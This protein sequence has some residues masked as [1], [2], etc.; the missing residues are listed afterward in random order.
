MIKVLL[1]DDEVL[2]LKGMQTF[3]PWGELGMEV[4]AAVTSGFAASEIIERESIDILVTDVRMPNMSGLE[5]ARKA[6]DIQENV[7][8]I[9]VSGYQDFHYVKQ[10]L[11]LNACSYI[12]KPMDDNELIE[13]LRKLRI[14]LDEEKKLIETELIYKRMV[15]MVK[16]EYL[17]QLLEGT[18]NI[19]TLDVLLVEYNLS[20][21]Q[22]PAS[23]VVI[24]RDDWITQKHTDVTFDDSEI[25][26]VFWNV[27]LSL[28]KEL[29]IDHFCRLSD[30]R[31]GLIMDCSVEIE[32]IRNSLSGEH[33]NAP[34]TVTIGVGDKVTSL[35]DLKDSFRQAKSALDYKVFYG[36]GKVIHHE[37]VQSTQMKDVQSLDIQLD[38]LLVAMTN[39]ELV[40]VHDELNLLYGM[41]NNMRSKFTIQNFTVFLIM[42]LEA[43]LQKNNEDLFQM[44]N[45]DFNSL[46]VLLQYETIDE[47]HSWLRYRVYELSE[48]L[49]IKK[50]KK[51]WKLVQDIV[52]DVKLRLH[53]NITLKDVADKYSFSPNYLGQIFKEEMKTNFSDYVSLLRMEKA[54]ELLLNTNL[55]V[56]E[57]ANLIGYRYLPYFSRQFKDF[58]GKTPLEYRRKL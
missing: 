9:F 27:L 33:L 11:S 51:N 18:W 17:L 43:H 16:N 30:R 35:Y 44:L 4:I 40:K 2:D 46:D 32:A 3:I 12:V 22:W 23:I 1:V 21:T 50:Q 5:L 45:L 14:E 57:I 49:Q 38:A 26:S 29:G 55:K 37:A 7:K 39:Y 48:R 58:H 20:K 53:E 31:L 41:A 47:I 28:C 8:I 19:E 56:Y 52:N 36:K 24:E 34:F 13:S 42:K 6:L 15:P 25:S 10:A 54:G